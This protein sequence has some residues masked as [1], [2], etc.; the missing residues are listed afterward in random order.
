MRSQRME[1]VLVKYQT[2]TKRIDVLVGS[3]RLSNWTEFHCKYCDAWV[4][5]HLASESPSPETRVIVT[6]SNLITAAEL[7]HRKGDVRY[8]PIF[9]IILLHD[10]QDDIFSGSRPSDPLHPVATA[11]LQEQTESAK[12]RIRNF[13]EQ[14]YAELER[15]RLRAHTEQT[16][17]LRALA[18][19]RSPRKILSEPQFPQ[20]ERFERSPK[21]ET[22]KPISPTKRVTSEFKPEKKLPVDLRDI[23]EYMLFEP[24]RSHD[25][26]DS[27][28]SDEEVVELPASRR[29]SEPMAMARSLPIP[30]PLYLEERRHDDRHE[31]SPQTPSDIAANIKALARSVHGEPIFGELPRPR[32]TKD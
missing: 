23:D 12:D 19:E 16:A 13:S 26:V 5:A 21:P 4:Y 32:F 7:E 11:W 22:S 20:F 18:N 31:K 6:M 14:Q 8:S 3:S 25:S 1:L 17:I 24:S 15:K 2:I 30:V 27:E 10:S 9:Q 29:P 28:G